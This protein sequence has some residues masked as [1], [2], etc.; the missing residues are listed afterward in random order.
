[1]MV[2]QEFLF[3]LQ[4]NTQ[5]KNTQNTQDKKNIDTKKNRNKKLIFDCMKSIANTL[6]QMMQD[7][8]AF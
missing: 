7:L 5:L 4:N 1:M 8:S 3:F 6:T 2:Q